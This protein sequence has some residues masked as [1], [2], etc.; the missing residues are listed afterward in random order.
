[1]ATPVMAASAITVIV[2]PRPPAWVGR[3]TAAAK[4]TRA[5]STEAIRKTRFVPCRST[6]VPAK[7]NAARRGIHSNANASPVSVADR[8]VAS[9]IS[10]MPYVV[11]ANAPASAVRGR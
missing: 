1:M 11:I 5:R 9:T 2:A 3:M 6:I 7:E 4:T 8:V 10:G